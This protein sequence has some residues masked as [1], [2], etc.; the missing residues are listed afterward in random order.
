MSLFD[1]IIVAIVTYL[2]TALVL[3]LPG[4]VLT[5]RLSK[6]LRIL[7]RAGVMTLAFAP[8]MFISPGGEFGTIA[9]AVLIVIYYWQDASFWIE[10]A[11]APIL[12]TFILSLM[13]MLWLDKERGE[14]ESPSV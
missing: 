5:R 3:F 2:L 7:I 4:W 1:F 13:L 8:G 14:R 9:P 12:I 11:V 6:K 10:L